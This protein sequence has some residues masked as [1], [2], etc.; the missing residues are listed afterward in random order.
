[1]CCAAVVRD[2]LF[3]LARTFVYSTALGVPTVVGARAAIEI[4]VGAEGNR[5]R[6]WLWRVVRACGGTS[7]ILVAGVRDEGALEVARARLEADGV[8]VGAIRPPT[9][10]AC[11]VR[12]S[13]C[14]GCCGRGEE[15]LSVEEL[16]V[17]GSEVGGA[18][19]R[20]YRDNRDRLDEEEVVRWVRRVRRAVAEA[21]A[22]VGEREE[23]KGSKGVRSRL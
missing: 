6:A 17:G 19:D 22:G 7:P 4:G 11:R 23:S 20:E 1:M 14:Y 12:M 18:G 16:G 5:R 9:V 2:A 21:E 8:R 10:A 13:L 3:N 15:F